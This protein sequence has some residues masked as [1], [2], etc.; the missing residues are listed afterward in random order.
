MERNILLIYENYSKDILWLK[1]LCVRNIWV[2]KKKKKH[3]LNKDAI[4]CEQSS[5]G[6]FMR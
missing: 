6:V 5:L 3:S 1:K 2:I 4:A